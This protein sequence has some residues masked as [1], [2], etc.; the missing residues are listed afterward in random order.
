V[1]G[2][3][4]A[5]RHNLK[6]YTMSQVNGTVKDGKLFLEIDVS[7]EAIKAAPLSSSGKSYTVGTTSGFTRFGHVGVSLNVTVPNKDYVA[8]PKK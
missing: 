2:W 4:P 7:P 8:P 6:G 3:R 1:T 5:N